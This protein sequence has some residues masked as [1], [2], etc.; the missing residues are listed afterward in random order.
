L[1]REAQTN[2]VC[3]KIKYAFENPAPQGEAEK[4]ERKDGVDF[5]RVMA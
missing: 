5:R 4:K 3:E 1:K 2:Y